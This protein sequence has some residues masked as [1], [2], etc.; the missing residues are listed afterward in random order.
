MCLTGCTLYISIK[1]P[2]VDINTRLVTQHPLGGVCRLDLDPFSIVIAVY[3]IRLNRHRTELCGCT[4][5]LPHNRALKH[6]VHE[7]C[8]E[9]GVPV[10]VVTPHHNTEDLENKE[11][12]SG[13]FYE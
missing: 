13:M 5:S 9:A 7:Q 1:T 3:R 4:H 11:G 6:G 8:K 10:F 12:C 2:S